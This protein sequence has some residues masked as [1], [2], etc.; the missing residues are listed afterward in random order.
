MLTLCAVLQV[1]FLVQSVQFSSV[2]SHDRLSRR[3][4]MRDDSAEI[5][6]QS[7]LFCFC[8]CRRP[9]WAVLA[10][11][12]PNP[13]PGT[14]VSSRRYLRVK[15]SSYA[16]HPPSLFEVSRCCL[17][18][19]FRVVLIHGGPFS[20]LLRRSSMVSSVHA[21]P[22]PGGRT[23]DG[24]KENNYWDAETKSCR[25][26][27]YFKLIFRWSL[28][29]ETLAGTFVGNCHHFCCETFIP[30]FWVDFVSPLESYF[31]CERGWGL[32]MGCTIY[33][34]LY[35][36]LWNIFIYFFCWYWCIW[37][38]RFSFFRGN[39]FHSSDETYC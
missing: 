14:T 21:S 22:P 10:R 27:S 26:Q 31:V 35:A 37:P 6:F 17:W 39:S 18:N 9:F 16:L 32:G 12:N 3:G 8:F 34:Y 36:Q 28:H 30:S 15:E 38:S 29:T 33:E 23:C 25:N 19:S 13:N 20:S 1:V 24:P 4:D 5:L 7:F 2:Q 11:V